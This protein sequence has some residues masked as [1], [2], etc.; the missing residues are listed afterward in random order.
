MAK[1]FLVG[2]F[3]D[4]DSLMRAIRPLRQESF[5]IYDVYSPYPVHGLDDAMGVRR[6]RLPWVTL[7]AGLTGLT[8]AICFEFYTSILDWPLNVGGKP[9]NS[10]LAFVPVMFELTVL[11]AG[12]AS[13]AAL[14]FRSKLYPGKQE[15]LP[16]PGVTNNTFALVVRK[17][18]NQL[19]QRRIRELMQRS[20]ARD[21]EEK[22]ASL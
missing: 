11:F 20:G 22:E 16:S 10:T 3:L 17:P 9:D 13:V 14:F 6:T 1:S 19:D 7:L 18:S 5:R 15:E 4:P 8:F 2:T 12:L 21:V